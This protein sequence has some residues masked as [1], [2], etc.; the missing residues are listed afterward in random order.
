MY[1]KE[2]QSIYYQYLIGNQQVLKA[3]T[4]ITQNVRYRKKVLEATTIYDLYD[5]QD[6]DTPEIIAAKYYGDSGLH[7]IVML[8]NQ[9]YSLDDFPM[10]NTV[11]DNY[12]R[13]KYNTFVVEDMTYDSNQITATIPGHGISFTPEPDMNPILV[14]NVWSEYTHPVSLEVTRQEESALNGSF[15]IDYTSSDEDTVVFT[16]GT[17][18][19]TDKTIVPGATIITYSQEQKIIHHTE[20]E[21]GYEVDGGS[22]EVTSLDWE[23]EQN[24]AKRRIK[25]IHP[26]FIDQILG[27]LTT[28]I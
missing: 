25:L 26:D 7:W 20:N 4:D 19:D 8:T 3:V 21:D 27:E 16:V 23:I 14:Q 28:L 18:V 11:F 2:F 10:N 9:M 15:Q 1:F 24:E 6:G 22:V 13:D 17:W 12:I 5:I